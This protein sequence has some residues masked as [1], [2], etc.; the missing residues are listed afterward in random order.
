MNLYVEVIGVIQ[1]DLH[2]IK[3]LVDQQ[4]D[5]D[6]KYY[7]RGLALGSVDL[8]SWEGRFEERGIFLGQVLEDLNGYSKDHLVR[9]IETVDFV[10]YEF[11]PG[12]QPSVCPWIYM[13]I[14]RFKYVEGYIEELNKA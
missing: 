4:K 12:I 2:V 8:V 5:H 3:K 10:L 9:R 7:C 1:M 14:V 6:Q 11:S 13:F